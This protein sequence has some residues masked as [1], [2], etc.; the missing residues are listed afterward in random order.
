MR[1][2]VKWWSFWL[3]LGAA[4]YAVG[5]D[6]EVNTAGVRRGSA[7]LQDSGID[8]QAAPALDAQEFSGIDTSPTPTPTDVDVLARDAGVSDATPSVLACP[9]VTVQPPPVGASESAR[10]SATV[11]ATSTDGFC[12]KTCDTPILGVTWKGFAGRT[13]TVNGTVV[14]LIGADG[15]INSDA[16]ST[17]TAA[18]LTGLAAAGLR[19]FQ[20]SA[21]SSAAA[22]FSWFGA[23]A[24]CL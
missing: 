21:G 23:T 6:S 4:L 5:C 13:L 7:V 24:A 19:T 18:A 2:I 8:T 22:T 1:E 9:T 16:G 10:W 11:Q 12:F 17:E 20:V 14:Y 3:L 15:K